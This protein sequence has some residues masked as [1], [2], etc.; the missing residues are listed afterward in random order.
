MKKLFTLLML[1]SVISFA[2]SAQGIAPK[3]QNAAQRVEAE[4]IAYLT[5]HMDLSTEESQV[6]WPV[7][8]K[9]EKE[10]KALRTAERDAFKALAKAM[11]EGQPTDALLNTYLK[12]AQANTNLH[13]AHQKDYA[14]V[15]SSEK[16]AKFYI[17][18]EKFRRMQINKLKGKDKGAHKGMPHPGAAP[19]PAPAPAPA[20]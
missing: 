6:F 1:A 9:V 8:N 14:K 11:K 15:L 3:R 7:Y 5:I 16:L 17:S 20:N 4:L 19:A 10:Q 13:I 18:Q 12:A 2:A